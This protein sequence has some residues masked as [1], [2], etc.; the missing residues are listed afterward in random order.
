MNIDAV[1]RAPDRQHRHGLA[2]DVRAGGHAG[3]EHPVEAQHELVGLV[4]VGEEA[5][6]AEAVDL[7]EPRARARSP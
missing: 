6:D 4:V 5:R 7:R 3:G 2:R 1:E